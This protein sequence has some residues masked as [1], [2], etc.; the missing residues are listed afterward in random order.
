MFTYMKHIL[1]RFGVLERSRNSQGK[2]E[3]AFAQTEEKKHAVYWAASASGP[4]KVPKDRTV[5][6]L[7]MSVGGMVLSEVGECLNAERAQDVPRRSGKKSSSLHSS[8]LNVYFQ[9]G[10]PTV[11]IICGVS[12]ANKWGS[13]FS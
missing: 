6:S 11:N 10:S 5:K 4:V 2:I 12:D 9:L 7:A 8:G 1:E 3:R 13:R